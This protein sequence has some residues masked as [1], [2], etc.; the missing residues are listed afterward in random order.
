MRRILDVVVSD[1]NLITQIEKIMMP[2]ID[3]SLTEDGMDRI[4]ESIDCI[5]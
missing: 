1:E 5:I 4:E 2:C 3:H